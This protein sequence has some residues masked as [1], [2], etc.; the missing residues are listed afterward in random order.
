[1]DS[2]DAQLAG[3]TEAQRQAVEHSTGPLLILAG[4]GSGKTRVITHRVAS[5]LR[6][7]VAPQAIVALTFTNKAAQEMQARVERLVPG[8]TVWMGT[9]HRFCAQR[10]RHYASLLGLQPNYSIYDTSD[11]KAALKQS[12]ELS[13]VSTSHVTPEQIA[14]A[15]SG[16]KS[17]LLL[18]EDLAEKRFDS[19]RETIAARVYPHYRQLLL[20]NNAVDFDDLLLHFARLLRDFPDLRSELDARY[21]FVMVDEYQDTNLAQY[22]I[23]RGLSIDQPNLAVVGDPDQ[24]I[25]SWRGAD[26]RNVLQL[27]RDYPDLTT[28]RL[29]ENFRSAPSILRAADALIR[30]NRQRKHKALWTKRPE[31]VAVRLVQYG[32]DLE[33]AESI[34]D[35]IDAA[36]QS[37][38]RRYSDFAI[39]YRISALS[40]TLEQALRSRVI[41]YQIAR[42]LEFY[43][44]KEIKD[45]L[46]YL[47]LLNNPSHDVALRRIINVPIRGI[48]HKTVDR[49]QS[50][51]Q[52]HRQSL[53][54]ACRRAG[55]VPG[56]PA[57][58]AG[59]VAR[60]VAM[61]DRLVIKSAAPLEDL[62][63]ELLEETK[64]REYYLNQQDDEGD[65]N[66]VANLD[67]L[68]SAA[69]EFDA[70]HPQDGSLERFLE[71]VALVSDTDGWDGQS[72]RVSLMTLHAAKGLE[73]PCVYIVAVEQDTLPHSRSRESP[74][75]LEEER[76][77]LFV[78]MTRAID[79][80]QL[81]VARRRLVRGAPRIVAPSHFLFELPRD[82]FEI[83]ETQDPS[84]FMPR[85]GDWDVTDAQ[86]ID[87]EG[88][89]FDPQTFDESPR[90][91]PGRD[92]AWPLGVNAAR[93][94]QAAGWAEPTDAFDALDQT[95][96]PSPQKPKR[97]AD[98]A[99]VKTAAE[100]LRAGQLAGPG[101]P[102]AFRVGMVVT[103]P[104]YGSGRIRALSGVGMKR[105]AEIVFFSD[106]LPHK[107]V[108]ALTPLSIEPPADG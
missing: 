74:D 36:V 43:Q 3:L 97:I 93:M 108:L 28:I 65:N 94:R 102:D 51:A 75:E 1:M 34:A 89:D 8:R 54:E 41:P 58:T 31:T 70:R 96:A 98:P 60:F 45:V 64:L 79:Q 90:T 4:P 47:H 23:A 88:V 49:L 69:V 29:E 26:R 53:L 101:A 20:Q 7:G 78:G 5:L 81:S 82:E 22:A 73:F 59:L 15:I 39:C 2:W 14:A 68:V 63:R 25:Y 40:R 55:V 87:D 16:F 50:D 71:E 37:G 46:A 21:Q 12:I 92:P 66:P 11:A 107:F 30:H 44:R 35:A 86:W 103:H 80:L 48:G 67:E 56:L 32:S 105:T 6:Q 61:Y 42:G 19:S 62:L 27:E 106:G 57:R 24:S 38:Q 85:V 17:R 100:L 52:E 104:R 33:E 9:F 83:V 91:A 18:P 10:L 84:R 99:R 77:L 76:R 13:A 72:D 95:A